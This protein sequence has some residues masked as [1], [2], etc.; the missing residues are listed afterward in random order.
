MPLGATE[1][2]VRMGGKRENKLCGPEA[3]GQDFAGL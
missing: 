1:Y 3:A 2:A